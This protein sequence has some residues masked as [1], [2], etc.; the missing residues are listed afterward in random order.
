MHGER[1]FVS[2]LI[3]V[4]ALSFWAAG[5]LAADGFGSVKCDGDI[6]KA[7]I[8]KTLSNEPVAKLEQRHKAIGLRD[9]GSEEI[10]DSVSYI[11]WNICGASYH[12]LERGGRV[13]DVVR[14]EHSK[15]QPAFVGTCE[16][17]G[18]PVS[19]TA[20]AILDASGSAVADKHAAPDD[21]TL[22]PARSVWRIDEGRAKFVEM[23]EAKLACPRSGISTADGGP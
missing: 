15:A 2:K 3:V 8:G 17:A 12:V 9:E 10:S 13:T 20:F 19:Y 18:A 22:L 4:F 1:R 16:V 21:K 11:A 5:C 14:A 6:P 23:K 7:L